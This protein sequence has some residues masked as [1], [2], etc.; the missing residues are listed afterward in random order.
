V[1]HLDAL[2]R[3]AGQPPDFPGAV[4]QPQL[5]VLRELKPA[6]GGRH[7]LLEMVGGPDLN[8]A[9]EDDQRA[10]APPRAGL[11]GAHGSDKGRLPMALGVEH[12][13]PRGEAR[14]A[15]R[16]RQLHRGLAA[17]R[18]VCRRESDLFDEEK[19]CHGEQHRQNAG[20]GAGHGHCSRCSEYFRKSLFTG[21]FDMGA[22]NEMASKI[23]ISTGFILLTRVRVY[24][25]NLNFQRLDCPELHMPDGG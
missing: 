22:G 15:G 25:L 19:H 17:E 24:I 16:R 18:E 6:Q 1:H 12:H 3:R 23:S 14:L 4:R 8:A 11:G 10:R 2:P 21:S 20:A 9:Q 13:R 7:E 5:A